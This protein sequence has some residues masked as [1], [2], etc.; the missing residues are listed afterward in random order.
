VSDTPRTDAEQVKEQ[1][2]SGKPAISVNF[3]RQLERELNEAQVKLKRVGR[4]IAISEKANSEQTDN[5]VAASAEFSEA[6]A[7]TQ[8]EI[9]EEECNQLRADKERFITACKLALD[10]LQEYDRLVANGDF[11]FNCK[12]HKSGPAQRAIDAAMKKDR[13]TPEQAREGFQ[14]MREAA[15]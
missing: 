12:A 14:K 5:E 10:A 11:Y 4:L 1:A 2:S 7:Y 8:C 3:A 15:G 13:A 9:L 6:V